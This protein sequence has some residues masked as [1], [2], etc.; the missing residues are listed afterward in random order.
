MYYDSILSDLE[1][2]DLPDKVQIGVFDNKDIQNQRAICIVQSSQGIKIVDGKPTGLEKIEDEDAIKTKLQSIPEFQDSLSAKDCDNILS[3]LP[4]KSFTNV[5]FKSNNTFYKLSHD[6]QSRGINV[7]GHQSTSFKAKITF[8]GKKFLD[9]NGSKFKTDVRNK[10]NIKTI[11]VSSPSITQSNIY[12]IDGDECC[13]CIFNDQDEY[14]GI[15]DHQTKVGVTQDVEDNPQ[16]F[17]WKEIKG[18]N[19]NSTLMNLGGVVILWDDNSNSFTNKQLYEKFYLETNTNLKFTNIDSISQ[20]EFMNFEDKPYIIDSARIDRALIKSQGGSV[21]KINNPDPQIYDLN[22]QSTKDVQISALVVKIP[23]E[24]YNDVVK[25]FLG[26]DF[27]I[28]WSTPDLTLL[29]TTNEETIFDDGQPE[30]PPFIK[31]YHDDTNPI[32]YP[33]K[34][35]RFGDGSLFNETEYENL[36][37]DP[38]PMKKFIKEQPNQIIKCSKVEIGFPA[39]M[40]LRLSAYNNQYKTGDFENLYTIGENIDKFRAPFSPK[41]EIT[42]ADIAGV[43]QPPRS[44]DV[45]IPVDFPQS[46]KPNSL[47]YADMLTQDSSV[48]NT[49]SPIGAT[50]KEKHP[51]QIEIKKDFVT[52]TIHVDGTNF[53]LKDFFG[54]DGLADQFTFASFQKSQAR[55]LI[56]DTYKNNSP[57]PRFLPLSYALCKFMSWEEYKLSRCMGSNLIDEDILPND[58]SS[59]VN[60]SICDSAVPKYCE[61]NMVLNHA[62]FPKQQLCSCTNLMKKQ[63]DDVVTFVQKFLAN[64]DPECI[65][66]ACQN[67]TYTNFKRTTCNQIKSANI[68]QMKFENQFTGE[69]GKSILKFDENNVILHCGEEQNCSDLQNCISVVDQNVKEIRSNL[70]NQFSSGDTHHFVFGQTKPNITTDKQK[71]SLTNIL[72]IIIVVVLIIFGLYKIIKK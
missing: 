13:Y 68:C 40:K 53:T 38:D 16:N 4:Q 26:T 50:T 65:Y 2:G 32:T 62:K 46:I 8:D 55:D 25:L 52:I 47:G 9:T 51:T 63:N 70:E 58:P 66:A 21:I 71:T 44:I 35:T 30:P 15:L 60:A 17:I 18:P 42:P 45:T 43:S 1:T 27:H 23:T 54:T 24:S 57:I 61:S 69:E 14:L 11:F 64:I 10:W 48:F 56:I 20:D 59:I 7:I 34:V 28:L 5:Q 29:N 19:G 31:F 3:L 67:D 37:S 12:T 22:N 41:V 33:L 39:N 36:D 49:F 72:I 6:D